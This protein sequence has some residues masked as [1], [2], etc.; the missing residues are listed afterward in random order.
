MPTTSFDPARQVHFDL[1]KGS[2]RAGADERV[3]LVSVDALA[4][5]VKGAPRGVIESV[6]R[7][8]GRGIGRRIAMGLG[9][10][11]KVRAAPVETFVSHLGGELAL[12]GYGVARLER[13]GRAMVVAVSD[14]ALGE[15]LLA[16]ILEGAL[17]AITEREV[18]CTPLMREGTTVRL[19]VSSRSAA[20]R[21]RSWLDARVAW[22][23]ALARLNVRSGGAA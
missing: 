5:L 2:V 4:E 7:I 8:M 22:G 23:E 17:G 21:V 19:L 3:A 6:G 18:T 9:D 14:T 1:S 15:P 13:W 12:A 11:G 16:A 20:E 10:A